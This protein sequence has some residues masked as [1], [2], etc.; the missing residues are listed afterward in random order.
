M[1]RLITDAAKEL[2][3]S[4][5]YEQVSIRAIAEKIEYS[6]ATIYLYFKDKDEILF[7]LH[8][9]GFERLFAFQESVQSLPDPLER[10]RKHGEVYLQFGLENPEFYDL[11][12]IL[13][14]PVKVI[15]ERKEW[16]KGGRSYD[17]LR[18]NVRECMEAGVIPAMDVEIATFAMWSIVHGIVSLMVR[19]RCPMI[20]TDKHKAV[21]D[22]AFHYVMATM[23][24]L[25]AVS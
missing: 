4:Q 6:P 3:L 22:S 24:K 2:F 17:C 14:A 18:R 7:A 15:H 5:G 1:Q 10:L 8:N 9:E 16:E 11:M 21:A 20:P 12:F 23:E 25:A 13:R 19:E